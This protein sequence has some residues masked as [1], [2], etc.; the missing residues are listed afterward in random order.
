MNI[1]NWI[2]T[3]EEYDK[4]KP[5]LC[6]FR[7]AF[8][9]SQTGNTP[10][11]AKVSADTRYR[12]YVN[13]HFLS[14][15]PRKGDEKVWFYEKVDIAP[16]L[17]EGSNVLCMS[18]LRY[19]PVPYK[20]YRSAWRT[21]TPGMICCC[22]DE[23]IPDSDKSWKCHVVKEVAITSRSRDY[24]RLFQEETVKAS[25][26][27]NG[28]LKTEFD[29]SE[30]EEPITFKSDLM[31]RSV[32][33]MF[34]KEREIPFLYQEKKRFKD[35]HHIVSSCLKKENYVRLLKEGTPL[36]IPAHSHEIVDLIADRLT[37]AYLEL[38]LAE[39]KGAKITLLESEAYGKIKEENGMTFL[40]KENRLDYE[41]GDL[42]GPVDEYYVSGHGTLE[43]PEYY[44]PFHFREF[45]LL[46]LEIE[47]AEEEL[48]LCDLSYRE[49]AYP[50]EKKAYVKTD[51][52][53]LEDIWRI[54][55][56]TLRMCMHETYEDC[57]GYEQLQYAMDTRSQILYTYCISGDDRLAR[58]AIDDFSRSQRPDGLVAACYP[59][60]KSNIIPS[61][62]VYYVLMLYDHMMYFGDKE[63]LKKYFPSVMKVCDFYISHINEKGLFGYLENMG[64]LNKPYWGYIDSIDEW[65]MGVI[66]VPEGKET[67]M[68]SLLG[69]TLLEA[70]AKIASY[71]GYHDI[72]KEY[73]SIYEDMKQAVRKHCLSTQG[74]IQDAPGVEK[75]SNISQ[76][77]ATLN[78][79]FTADEARSAMEKTL[80]GSLSPCSLSVFFYHFRALEK[81]SLYQHADTMFDRWRKM[82]EKNL[83]T[84]VE[85]DTPGQQRSDC[86]AWS[87]TPL[88]ELTSAIL[89][90]RPAAP[91]YET[92]SFEPQTSFINACEGEVMTPKGRIKASWKKEDGKLIKNIAV[93]E[94]VKISGQ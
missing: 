5:V 78:D 44:E 74:L 25:P 85:H 43:V 83:S 40:T 79:V 91:G 7:K 67:T 86:H 64:Y 33:P 41:Y 10:V 92:V 56:N 3:A 13:G 18:V 62:S 94:G 58:A 24:V 37:T 69:I 51:D 59:T 66:P 88:Y 8:N 70:S 15:G 39:G 71:I 89:G 22:E 42:H 60:F 11:Y 65:I 6:Y 49:T 34:M 31:T 50:L 32:S 19:P 53:S 9:L 80:D 30:W 75:Y 23:R 54:S 77:F 20:G 36:I 63:F 2:W 81:T 45:Y 1:Q 55:E 68:M 38:S 28:W 76:I 27:L 35:V 46:R 90:I 61:F 17:K 87:S 47:T 52:P 21:A 72:E 29:D 48:V 16:Y 14:T 12:F 82:L 26:L 57:P 4:E 73:L 93:P 84:C